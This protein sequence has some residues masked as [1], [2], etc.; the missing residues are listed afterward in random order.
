MA[1]IAWLALA[2]ILT[3]LSVCMAGGSDDPPVLTVWPGETVEDYG[4]IGTERFLQI[5][6]V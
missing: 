5:L 4:S 6:T 1:S 2:M 3:L